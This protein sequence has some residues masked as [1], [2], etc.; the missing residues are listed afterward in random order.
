ME[1][2][3]LFSTIILFVGLFYFLPALSN[4]PYLFVKC[5]DNSEK[6]GLIKVK[7]KG[8]LGF[9]ECK[10]TKTPEEAF[11][12]C[13]ADYPDTVKMVYYKGVDWLPGKWIL[14]YY[15]ST[16]QWEDGKLELINKTDEVAYATSSM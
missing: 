14:E 2:K 5:I 13:L 10:S 12:L 9:P 4:C 16:Y 15:A 11:D 6:I 7:T 3:Q 1:R 8:K